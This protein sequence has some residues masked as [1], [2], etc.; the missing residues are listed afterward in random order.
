MSDAIKKFLLKAV[1]TSLICYIIVIAISFLLTKKT[2]FLEVYLLIPYIMLINLGFHILL[3]K[4]SVSNNML[5]VNKYI[6]FSGIKLFIY[7]ISILIYLIFIKFE[8]VVFLL[9]FIIIYFIFT[10]AEITSL[11]QIFKKN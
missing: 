1:I 4:A 9:S 11:L 3:I 5:F 6:A 7:L 8:I 10:V 2:S